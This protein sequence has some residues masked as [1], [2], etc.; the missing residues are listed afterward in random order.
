MRGQNGVIWQAHSSDFPEF[1]D[2]HKTK[3]THQKKDGPANPPPNTPKKG[4]VNWDRLRNGLRLWLKRFALLTCKFGKLM[5]GQ[6]GVI[7]Q[8]HSSDFPEF[9]DHH[10]TKTTHQKKD[11]PANPPP[12]T[13]KKGRVNWDRLRN[14]LRL[15]E[16]Q[17]P[18]LMKAFEG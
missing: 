11:R 7:W 14:G 6:N 3:T 10:K 17:C 9:T 8:A 5:R 12:N 15:R 1:T 18:Y 16:K 2:H 13:P 4:R